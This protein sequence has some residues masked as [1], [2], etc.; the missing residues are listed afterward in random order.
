MTKSWLIVAHLVCLVT[1]APRSTSQI[2]TTAPNS[3]FPHSAVFMPACQTDCMS[4]MCERAGHLQFY[5]MLS[6]QSVGLGL[7][8][9]RTGCCVQRSS[10]VMC[11]PSSMAVNRASLGCAR[12]EWWSHTGALK[13]TIRWRGRI[14]T[15]Y[16]MNASDSWMMPDDLGLQMECI[17]IRRYALLW[18]QKTGLDILKHNR[19]SDC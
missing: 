10:W 4:G 19:W 2:C 9:H 12:D 5:T 17:C 18:L 13:P 14:W 8:G 1:R 3:I 15:A 6:D 11:E 7:A 16:L